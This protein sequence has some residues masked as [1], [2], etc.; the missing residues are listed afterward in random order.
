M[1]TK[2][3]LVVVDWVAGSLALVLLGGLAVL[4]SD[5]KSQRVYPPGPPRH[6]IWGNL[7]NFPRVRWQ[8]TFT[9][10]QKSWG[11]SYY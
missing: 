9:E 1:V 2:R 7:F 8:E 4:K 10:W 3:D 11:M 5:S 6:P